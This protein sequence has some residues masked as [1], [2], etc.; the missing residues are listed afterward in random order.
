MSRPKFTEPTAISFGITI[1]VPVEIFTFDVQR[2][3]YECEEHVTKMRD[4]A[5]EQIEKKAL[6]QCRAVLQWAIV[7]SASLKIAQ[8]SIYNTIEFSF[9]FDNFDTMLKFKEELNTRINNFMIF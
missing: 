4:N 5:V 1:A 2:N 8:Y 7:C 3:I 6:D 9:L